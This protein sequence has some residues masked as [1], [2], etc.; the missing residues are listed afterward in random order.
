MTRLLW[1]VQSR[2]DLLRPA[3]FAGRAEEESLRRLVGGLLALVGYR[4]SWLRPVEQWEPREGGT[5]SVFSSLAHHLLA[6]YPVPPVMH[7]A[8]FAGSGWWAYRQRHWFRHVGMGGSLRTAGFPIR[9]TKRM[10]YEF[11]LAPAHFDIGFALR[12]AQ[13]RGLG[14]SDTIARVVASTRL[15]REFFGEAFWTSVIHLF[16]RTRG[17]DPAHVDLIVEYLNH[18]KFV[19]RTII[20]GEDTE[21]SIDPPRPD[22][23]IKGCTVTSLLRRAEEWKAEQRPEAP[24]RKRFEWNRSEIREY[25][26]AEDETRA[27]TIRE[28][29]DSDDLAA[30]GKAMKHCVATYTEFCVRR[31]STIWSLGLEGP[32]GRRR[33]ATIEVDP[34]TR[35]V[36]QA[37]M[38]CNEEPDE[39]CLSLVKEWASRE[40]LTVEC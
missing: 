15:G 11:S 40:G 33:L 14:G 22:L 38:K 4:R 1:N 39:P 21:I 18:Q 28:L 2:S 26:R 3:R 7:S 16:L 29:L 5:H 10:A 9:L 12:W 34:K 32:E 17:L 23:S 24:E 31:R 37:S 30:E 20:V 35:T 27:W 25:Q 13:V 19:Q 8:W 36:V 6:N